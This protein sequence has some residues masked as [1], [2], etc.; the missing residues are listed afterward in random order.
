MQ[1]SQTRAIVRANQHISRYSQDPSWQRT[2]L[3]IEAIGWRS[4]AVIPTDDGSSLDAVHALA[5]IAWQQ[6]SQAVVVADIRTIALPALSAVREELR[7]R[8]SNGERVLI[9][10]GSLSQ[11]PAAATIAR[12]ADGIVICIVLGK[13]KRK[14]IDSIIKGFGK[15]KI[16]GTIT[17][18]SHNI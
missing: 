16:I 5:S 14:S 6:R 9:A 15:N 2:W 10:T 3:E 13:S 8:T 7:R 17:L 18:R 11:S 4:I 1:E 12:E